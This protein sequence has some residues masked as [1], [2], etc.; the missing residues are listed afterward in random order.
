[1]AIYR[2]GPP[3]AED[4]LIYLAETVVIKSGE[5]FPFRKTSPCHFAG[6]ACVGASCPQFGVFLKSC[7][8]TV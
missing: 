4:E 6:F 2:M 1:M 5:V 8:L 7:S 3:S